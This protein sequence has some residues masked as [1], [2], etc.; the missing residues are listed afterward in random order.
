MLTV[1][2]KKCYDI[3]RDTHT[4]GVVLDRMGEDLNNVGMTVARFL[5]YQ[6]AIAKRLHLMNCVNKITRNKVLSE[7]CLESISG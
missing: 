4:T 1:Q 7:K 3:K 2:K 5:L 6:F